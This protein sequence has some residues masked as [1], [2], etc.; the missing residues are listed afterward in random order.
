MILMSSTKS[1]L[2][3]KFSLNFLTIIFLLTI[4]PIIAVFPEDD[5]TVIPIDSSVDTQIQQLLQD[6]DVPSLAA[7]IVVND[8][9]VWAK[10]YGDQPSLDTVY[11]LGSI[12][13]P[14]IATAILQLV[15]DGTLA[16]DDDVSNYLPF[17]F[18]HPNYPTDPITIQM[19]L[20]HRSSFL[21]FPNDYLLWDRDPEMVSWVTNTLGWD[22]TSWTPISFEEYMEEVVS[23]IITNTSFWLSN[24]PGTTYQYS[25]SGVQLILP[26]IIQNVT[27]QAY[28]IYIQDN[29]LTPLEME[30]SG[31]NGS[32]FAQTHAKPYL[33][34][35]DINFQFPDEYYLGSYSISDLRTS[36]PDLAKFMIAHMNQGNYKGFKLLSSSSITQMHT[37]HTSWTYEGNN[38]AYGLGWEWKFGGQGHGGAVPGFLADFLMEDDLDPSFGITYLINRGSSWVQDDALL[39]DFQPALRTLLFEEGARMSSSSTTTAAGG[40]GFDLQVLVLGLSVLFLYLRKRRH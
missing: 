34:I 38:W 17:E 22:V 1:K 5:I 20:S 6:Y 21:E 37:K 36:L 4:F 18:R 15:E 10:G 12:L 13:K 32:N 11:M 24:K 19:C 40:P 9:L 26:Y 25:N 14:F 29:I 23:S 33:R 31:F 8:S 16:L 35:N 2:Y 28:E 7:G 27:S 39:N 30:N 3:K